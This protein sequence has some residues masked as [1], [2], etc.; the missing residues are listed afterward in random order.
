MK[1]THTLARYSR[2]IN[3]AHGWRLQTQTVPLT[4]RL[5]RNTRIVSELDRGRHHC[6]DRNGAAFSGHINSVEST[7]TRNARTAGRG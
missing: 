3:W 6:A 2:L 7:P 1:Q 4:Q 5:L